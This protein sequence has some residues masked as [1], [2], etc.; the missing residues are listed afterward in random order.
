MIIKV[1]QV[2]SRRLR[3][4]IKCKNLTIFL[5]AQQAKSGPP[6]TPLLGQS[7]INAAQFC[8]FFNKYTLET[9]SDEPPFFPLNTK[10]GILGGNKF[11]LSFKVSN[12]TFLLYN[13]LFFFGYLSILV[14]YKVFLIKN[15]QTKTSLKSFLGTFRAFRLKYMKSRVKS[16]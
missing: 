10:I 5:P 1:N 16:R 12:T 3:R 6:L 9:L 15:Y 14:L 7:G 11:L 8:T 4:K 2:T 13:Y